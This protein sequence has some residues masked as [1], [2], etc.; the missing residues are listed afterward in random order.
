MKRKVIKQGHNTLTIT[1]PCK[2]AREQGIAPGDEINFEEKDKELLISTENKK[3]LMKADLD[4]TNVSIPVLWRQLISAYRAGYD[5]ITIHFDPINGKD[6]DVYTGFGYQT[7][8]WLFPEGML[9]LSPIEAIQALVNRLVGV[10]IIDQKENYCIVKE[11]GETMFKEFDNSL[12]RIFLLLLSMSEDILS[13]YKT[14]KKEMLKAIHLVD[15]N[16]DRFNDFCLRVLNKRGYS[17]YRK[18]TPMYNLIFM[19]EMLGDE[20]KKIALHMLE[21]KGKSNPTVLK[22]L[23]MAMAQLKLFYKLFYTYS[24][25]AACEI[26]SADEKISES[27]NKNCRTLSDQEKEIIHHLKTIEN[28]ILSLTELRLDLVV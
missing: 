12:R 21:M 19:L 23:E 16:L 25:E 17:D 24:K 3:P 9:R 5:E 2:W 28:Y 6:K 22:Q 13:C 4:V 11:M 20:Y 27:F 18:T 14:N 7:L 8:Q 1:L 15:T 26:Y 10:E